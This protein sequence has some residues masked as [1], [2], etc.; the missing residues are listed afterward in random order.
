MGDDAATVEQLRAELRQVCDEKAALAAELAV[1]RDEQRA[2]AA[3]LRI[4]AGSPTD[5][6]LVLN[7][8]ASSAMRLSRSTRGTLA[9]QDG[10]SLRIVAV[11]GEAGVSGIHRQIG[12]VIDLSGHSPGSVSIR[13]RRTVHIP[14]RSS[15]SFRA[16]F[17]ASLSRMAA[18]AV[19]V[20][21]VREGR[22]I[23]NITV[24]R[25]VAA[26]YSPNDIA[27][28]ET[29]ADQAVIAIKNARLFE[30]LE[31]RNRE[32]G[33]ALEQ[34]TATAEVLRV[35]ASSPTDLD[36]VLQSIID[37]AARLCDAQGGTILQLRER[38]G[39]FSPRVSCGRQRALQ[40]GLYDDPFEDF[41]GLPISAGTPP[42]RALHERRT[43]HVHDMAEAIEI[44]FPDARPFQPIYGFRT[45]VAVPL[46][47][48]DLPIGIFVLV[49]YEVQPFTDAQIALLETFASQ[50]VIAIENARLFEA[51][52]RRN[53]ELQESNR[54]VSE[55]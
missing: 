18:T 54:Q 45:M 17:P 32:L 43:I 44:E 55:A 35:I 13:E 21:L 20:P 24:S 26:P 5:L 47:S 41:P 46:V 33:E 51:L 52:E 12:D 49:Q 27:L 42:G 1:S 37:S 53:R 28:V 14:D 40:E 23:G 22:A 19:H 31:Q 50:A 10:D 2:T 30:E 38:D 39:L 3:T 6:Q 25:D 16:E 9:I 4:V 36:S 29:F 48:N 8:V 11:A 15:P 7:A 34:Q